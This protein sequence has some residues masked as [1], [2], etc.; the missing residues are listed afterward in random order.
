MAAFW[1]E[2]EAEKFV[3]LELKLAEAQAGLDKAKRALVEAKRHEGRA[4]E[5]RDY[6]KNKKFA[7]FSNEECWIYQGDGEDHLE[8]LVCPV[9]ISANDLMAILAGKD[10]E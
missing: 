10:K 3:E 7:G 9:V 4:I 1:L 5:E 2:E 6:W 8:S